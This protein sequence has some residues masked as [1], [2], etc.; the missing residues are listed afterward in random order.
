MPVEGQLLDGILKHAHDSCTET[1][2][3]RLRYVRPKQFGIRALSTQ[4]LVRHTRP[5]ANSIYPEHFFSTK[6]VLHKPTMSPVD[7]R[8]GVPHWQKSVRTSLT[9]R[10]R[11]RCSI[12]G[13]FQRRL[14]Q[15]FSKT[16]GTLWDKQ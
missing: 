2:W 1:S 13:T 3:I 8:H 9:P 10:R 11:A 6:L 7:L 14:V 15:G 16:K 5:T 12:A 4:L